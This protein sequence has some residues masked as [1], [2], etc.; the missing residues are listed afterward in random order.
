[1]AYFLKTNPYPPM[2]YWG[3]AGFL[4]KI[5]VSNLSQQVS[6]FQQMSPRS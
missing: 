2:T 1:M 4:R 5:F 6:R 3:R